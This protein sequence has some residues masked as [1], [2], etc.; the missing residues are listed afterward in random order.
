MCNLV[1]KH[2]RHD[3]DATLEKFLLERSLVLVHDN[4]SYTYISDNL[5]CN[6]WDCNMWLVLQ[7]REEG[8]NHQ[9]LVLLENSEYCAEF[10]YYRVWRLT[11]ITCM[12]PT[13]TPNKKKNLNKLNKMMLSH[14]NVVSAKE[15]ALNWWLNHETR[16]S[17]YGF[18]FL[19]IIACFT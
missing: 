9:L 2:L 16:T 1:I 3:F 12:S 15:L 11:D 13:P 14:L 4:I 5:F 19:K 18:P 6:S 8:E 17:W 10:E 7:S